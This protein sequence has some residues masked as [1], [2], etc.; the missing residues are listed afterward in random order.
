MLFVPERRRSRR[1]LSA[2]RRER[3]EQSKPRIARRRAE[4]G[5]R[6]AVLDDRASR[7]AFR[8]RRVRKAAAHQRQLQRAKRAMYMEQADAPLCWRATT[9]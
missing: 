6:A 5:W 7:H 1:L 4:R 8:L 9:K 3:S 2:I